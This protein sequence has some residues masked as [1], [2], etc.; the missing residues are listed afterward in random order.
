ML[1]EMKV[2]ICMSFIFMLQE[3][4][5]ATLLRSDSK[6]IRK[7]NDRGSLPLIWLVITISFTAGFNLAYYKTWDILN[8]LVG[9]FG[10]IIYLTG[11]VIRWI[12]IVQL[13]KA[14]TV[15]VAFSTGQELKTDGIYR[16]VRHPGYLGALMMISG[17]SIGM[18]S[19][20]SVIVVIVPV[21]LAFSYRIKVEEDLLLEAF[22]DRYRE[23]SFKTKKFIPF[24]F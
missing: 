11:F 21:F 13:R 20:I 1:I 24:V 9:A 8:Y 18:N 19:I 16:L 15:D 6:T 4:I 10:L 3:L 12:A 5:L 22:G 7:R 17:I 14:F 23:Y 2:F